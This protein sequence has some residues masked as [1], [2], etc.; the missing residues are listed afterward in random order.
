M[1]TSSYPLADN[2]KDAYRVCDV[3]PLQDEQLERYYVDLS[4]SRKNNAINE[5]SLILEDQEASQSSTILFTGHQGCGKSTELRQIQ[6]RWADEYKVIYV[7][8][9]TETDINDAEYTDIYLIVIK[10][11]EFELRRNGLSFDHQLLANFEQWFKEIINETV[12]SVDKSIA[13]EGEIT[14]STKNPL[15]G[16][17][18]IAPPFLAKLLVKLLGQVKASHQG[19]KTVRQTLLKDVSRLKADINLLLDNGLKK[20]QKKFPKCKGFLIIFDNLDRTPI[21]VANHLFFDYAAQLK[22]LHCTIIY[23]V[24]ISVVYSSKNINN[25]FAKYNIIPMINIYNYDPLSPTDSDLVY[26]DKGLN[27]M[28]SLIEKRIDVEAIFEARLGLMELAK[29]SGGHVR[30]MMQMV[31]SS[32]QNARTSRAT[33]VNAEHINYAINQ[34]QFAFE[35]LIPDD[36]YPVLAKVYLS[37][38]APK[39]EIRQAMLSN[40]S[41]LEYNGLNRWNYLNPVVIRSRLFLRALENYRATNP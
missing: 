33:K 5:I 9:M 4:E 27:T 17:V 38:N 10:W 22:D 35:R 12:E 1:T 8:A 29:Y 19:K 18:S 3:V 13:I 36:H 34:E 21:N 31:R 26:S 20:W 28:I 23:T 25:A 2:L 14:L 7:D 32:I 6:S 37:K 24:P 16:I 30:Q 41:V 15:E 39:N 40:T 11:V